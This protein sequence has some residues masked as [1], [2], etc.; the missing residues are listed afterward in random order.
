MGALQQAM[1]AMKTPAGGG[2]S[3]PAFPT[4]GTEWGRWEPFREVGYGDGDAFTTLTDQ[5]GNGRHWTSTN[6]VP[7]Y[8]TNVLNGRP[9][10]DASVT[11]ANN[12]WNTGPTMA[13]L[14]AAHAFWVIKAQSD[15]AGGI[16]ETILALFGTDPTANHIPYV[17]GTVYDGNFSTAR[18]TTGNPTTS[19]SAAFVLYEQISTSSEWTR[20]INGA[21]SGNDFFTTA[22]NTVGG[23]AT[24]QLMT[25]CRHKLAGLYIFSAKLTTDRAAVISYLNDAAIFGTSFS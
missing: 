2:G 16:D 7:K 21:T 22:T 23:S 11:G 10:A 4:I 3:F 20:K 17:D 5:S 8:K 24:P 19:M 1:L 12:G 13:A 15:P 9:V 25:A 6:P 14:T 18:K